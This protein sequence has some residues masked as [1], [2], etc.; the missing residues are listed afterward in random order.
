MWVENRMVRPSSTMNWASMSTISVRARG[1]SPPVGSSRMSSSGSW[2]R[3]T[4]ICRRMPM[5]RLSSLTLLAGV[6]PAAWSSES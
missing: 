5:P 2:A 1:S 6:R 3:A 4:A